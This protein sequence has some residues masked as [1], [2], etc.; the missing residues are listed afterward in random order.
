MKKPYY[1]CVLRYAHDVVSE[2][3]VNVGILMFSKGGEYFDCRIATRFSRIKALYPDFK[4]QDLLYARK[5]IL[6]RIEKEKARLSEFGSLISNFDSVGEFSNKILAVDASSL[7]FASPKGGVASDYKE[8]LD[9]LFHRYVER[10]EESG[11]RAKKSDQ[12]VWKSFNK[13]FK[14]Q[15]IDKLIEE[16]SISGK[17]FEIHFKHCF[18]NGKIHIQQPLNFDLADVESIKD[19][20]FSWSGRIGDL[21]EARNLFKIYWLIGSPSDSSLIPAFTN[22]KN[23]LHEAP[24]EHEIVPEEDAPGHAERFRELL[25]NH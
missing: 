18:Q 1:Y 24:C 11:K 5:L 19:K 20:A 2:E 8:E 14:A 9:E 21:K 4:S 25:L 23:L 12:D 16:K 10:Y 6:E 17:Q 3:F 13:Q 7:Q 15:D 22:A